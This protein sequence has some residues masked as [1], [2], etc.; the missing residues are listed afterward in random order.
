MKAG[1]RERHEQD[2]A[3][4]DGAPGVGVSQQDPTEQGRG[5][6]GELQERA[7][8]TGFTA[9]ASPT[10]MRRAAAMRPR[11]RRHE[12]GDVEEAR[13]EPA[14]AGFEQQQDRQ[15]GRAGAPGVEL[16]I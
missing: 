16:A 15:D 6:G 7:G 11:G 8:E 3:G 4:G 1:R 10:S 14:F 9:S 5:D 13:D 2:A 12:P